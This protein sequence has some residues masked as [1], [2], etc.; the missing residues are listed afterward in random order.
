[1]HARTLSADRIASG[2]YADALTAAVT[3]LTPEAVLLTHSIEGRDAAA[4]LAVRIGSAVATDALAVLRDDVGIVARHSV[5]GGAFESDSAFTFGT[6]VVTLRQGQANTVPEAV[7]AQVEVLS[8][9]TDSRLEPV[10]ISRETAVVESGRPELRG[11]A[12]VVSGGRGLGSQEGFG[13]VGQ[14]ADALGAAIG[15]SRAAVDDGFVPYAHQVGQTGVSVAP[16]LYVALGISGAVQ[17][18]AGMQTS[19]AIVAINKDA[20]APIFEVADFGLVGD[21]FEIVP[22][23]IETIE[24]KRQGVSN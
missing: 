9:E 6:A 19:K 17:H 14:L 4:R 20:D 13:L 3:R 23:L 5:F 15:A 18:L 21:V 8:L 2:A 22:K 16:Q 24:A 7:T 10:V 1:L 12:R 11:A